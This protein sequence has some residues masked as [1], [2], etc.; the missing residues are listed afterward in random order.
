ML[1][2][3]EMGLQLEYAP[4]QPAP[5]TFTCIICLLQPEESVAVES[6]THSSAPPE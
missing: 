1:M 6:S 2:E 5:L 3:Q 4:K